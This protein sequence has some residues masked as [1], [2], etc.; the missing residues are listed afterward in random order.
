MIA[1]GAALAGAAALA[2]V[3]L[4]LAGQAAGM[5]IDIAKQAAGSVMN[6]AGGAMNQQQQ[7]K[8]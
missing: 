3:V 8:F 1:T 2:P 4:P 5:A 7:I 6:L